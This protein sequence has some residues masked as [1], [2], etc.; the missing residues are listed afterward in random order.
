[1]Y[2]FPPG[3]RRGGVVAIAS[4]WPDDQH[5]SKRGKAC[6]FVKGRKIGGTTLDLGARKGPFLV[7]IMGRRHSEGAKP[8][9]G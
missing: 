7:P 8:S 6:L 3:P 2:P 5:F 9:T 4:V 1:V